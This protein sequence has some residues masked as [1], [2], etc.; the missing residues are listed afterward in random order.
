MI[1]TI[2]QK[3]TS[4]SDDVA[5]LLEFSDSFVGIHAFFDLLILF[6]HV[7]FF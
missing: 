1:K 4:S 3:P 6:P 5:S 2:R 7:N